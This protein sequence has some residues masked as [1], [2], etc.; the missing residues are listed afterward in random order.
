MPWDD[1]LTGPT[2]Q[3]AASSA[4]RLRVRA[5]PGTGKTFSM[6]RRIARILEEGV[7]PTNVLVSTFTR[8]AARDLRD[9][10]T[11]LNVPGADLVSASTIHGLCY[12]ILQQNDVLKKTSRVARPLL[13]FESR[14]LLEDLNADCF[15][16]IYSR[17]KRLK[18]F[19]AAWA[20][21][22]HEQPGWPANPVD[23]AFQDMLLD[24]LSF[25]R[26]MLIG[27]LVPIALR[28]LIDNPAA[29]ELSKYKMILVDEYQDLNAAEQRVVDLLARNAELTVV[30]D[31]DQSIY[32][33]K[34]AHPAGIEDFHQR[35]L[36]TVDESLE[37][38]RRCPSW[39]V[40][41]ANVLIGQNT[42]QSHRVLQ[43]HETKDRGEIRI[44]QWPGTEE[45]AEGLARFIRKRVVNGEVQAGRVLVLSPSRILGYAIRD[46]LNG[47]GIQ[48][49]SF[50]QEQA[51]DGDPKKHDKSRTQ[52]AMTLLTLAANP[53][54]EVALRCWYG[55][56]SSTLRTAGWHRL[57]EMCVESGSSVPEM[58]RDIRKGQA[59]LPYDRKLPERLMELKDILKELEGSKGWDLVERLFP[60]EEDFQAIRELLTDVKEDCNAS[61]LLDLLRTSISQ[62]ELPT[63]VDYVRVMSLHKSK[64]LTADLVIVMGC[65]E[66]LMPR[67]DDNLNAQE[68]KAALEEQRRLFYVALTR[69]RRTLLLSSVKSLPRQEAYRLGMQV[70]G[71]GWYAT[72][73][74]S[75]FVSE[76]GP[77]R[78]TPILGDSLC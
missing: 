10:V 41:L 25:H 2:L 76:L 15:G 6:M 48:S 66:G 42:R 53:A 67:I 69:T 36:G 59:S 30:G 51:L 61:T 60:E 70:P 1:D 26:A 39:I 65:I 28:Y 54:D 33:F 23:R 56:G 72:T 19:E 34:H 57:R 38:C 43:S 18:A 9:A 5:G 35:H 3:V 68:Q 50:F 47:I 31:E 4:S 64:G 63:D 55:F 49:H 22:Q 16:D 7:P 40:E 78:P 77:T 20:R 27:E 45:E 44:V 62:P 11:Q 17:R 58:L 37:V 73:I 32:S 29:P 74:T 21:L 13:D 14:F 8:V 75:R 12:G 46:A 24:W 52:M 71:R